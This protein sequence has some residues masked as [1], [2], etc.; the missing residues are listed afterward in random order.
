MGLFLVVAAAGC[1][2][3]FIGELPDLSGED[4]GEVELGAAPEPSW[5]GAAAYLDSLFDSQQS[6]CRAYPGAPTFLVPDN[7]LV[8]SALGYLTSP[9]NPDP[10]HGAAITARL[11]SL[12]ACGCADEPGHDARTNH[13]LDPVVKKGAM[14]PLQPRSP[15]MRV[16]RLV[17]TAASSCGDPGAQCPGSALVQLDYPEFGWFADSCQA[18]ACNAPNVSGWDAEGVGQ[19]AAELLA[20]QILNRKNRGLDPMRLWQYLLAKWDGQGMRDRAAMTDGKY[21]TAKLALFKICARVLGQPLPA[22]VDRKL[23]AAQNAQGGIRTSYDLS[24]K[25]TLDQLGS[26]EAT[27]Y[28]ILAFRKPTTDF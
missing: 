9:A 3:T 14:V 27:A 12:K 16:P 15:C 5:P 6:L 24:G 8:A 4:P 2:G 25:F 19:G 20:L 17:P 10:M 11:Q 23:T 21:S 18:T 26:A 13:H 22:G 1:T 28:T 7:V